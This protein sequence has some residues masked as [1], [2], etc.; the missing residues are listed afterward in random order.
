MVF[1]DFA[2]NSLEGATFSQ[3]IPTI[4]NETASPFRIIPAYLNLA[5]IF[6]TSGTAALR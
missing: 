4:L 1:I 6:T 3:F 5:C 2:Q